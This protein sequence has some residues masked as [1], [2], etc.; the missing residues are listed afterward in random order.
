MR[1]AFWTAGMGIIGFCFAWYAQDF[2]IEVR[3]PAVGTT[4]PA[5]IGYSFGTIFDQQNGRCTRPEVRLTLYRV[6]DLQ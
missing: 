6:E 2:P 1:R 4:W 5:S 3:A